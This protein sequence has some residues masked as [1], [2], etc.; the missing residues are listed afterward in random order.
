M[1]RL[2]MGTGRE[3]LLVLSETEQQQ[4]QLLSLLNPKA[5]SEAGVSPG[6]V[7]QD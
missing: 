1:F 2:L 3:S 6:W 5:E 7:S 4:Q